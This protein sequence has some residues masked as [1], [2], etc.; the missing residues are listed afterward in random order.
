MYTVNAG[1]A[2]G[3]SLPIINLTGSASIRLYLR[4]LWVGFSTSP[5]DVATLFYLYRTTD[6][7]SGGTALTVYKADPLKATATGTA[8]SG[9]FSTAPTAGDVLGRLAINQRG[10]HQFNF[11]DNER[12]VST[13][14]ANNGL[15][16]FSASSGA[17]PTADTN[18]QWEE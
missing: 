14:S 16:L 1:V 4:K 7:G 5:A 15:E 10:T 17:T 3:T 9:T 18:V 2:C 11:Y 8:K 6:A 12:L 13:A